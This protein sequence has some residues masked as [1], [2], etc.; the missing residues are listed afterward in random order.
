MKSSL[1]LFCLLLGI[2][3]SAF[4]SWTPEY[5]YNG[6]I[7]KVVQGDWFQAEQRAVKLGGHLVTIN[8]AAEEAWLHSSF[9]TGLRYWIGLTDRVKEGV[10]QWVTGEPVTYTHWAPGEPEIYSTFQSYAIMNAD[11]QYRWYDM[12]FD[13]IGY[14]ISER[15]GEPVPPYVPEPLAGVLFVAGGAAIAFLRKK[16]SKKYPSDK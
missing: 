3:G 15:L 7:Y 9:G 1:L 11:R 5:E 10:W 14:G 4:A 6:H 2:A 13:R 12:E 16:I 8:D